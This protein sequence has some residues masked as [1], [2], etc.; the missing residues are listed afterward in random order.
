MAA[1]SVPPEP[2]GTFGTNLS[3]NDYF[4]MSG[5]IADLA[6]SRTKRA[7]KRAAFMKMAGMPAMPATTE[8][9]SALLNPNAKTPCDAVRSTEGNEG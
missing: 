7:R 9:E 1:G 6:E 5:V 8:S 2:A 3:R 4:A